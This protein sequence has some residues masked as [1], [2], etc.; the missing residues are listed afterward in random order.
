M[1]DATAGLGEVYEKVEAEITEK[2]RNPHGGFGSGKGGHYPLAAWNNQAAMWVLDVH[3]G[4][5]EAEQDL[6]YGITRRVRP[7]RGGSERNT[8]KILAGLP[9]LS[10]GADY[11]VVRALAKRLE[12][13]SFRG[14]LI[15]GLVDPYS[16]L[17]R[18][19]GQG[20]PQCPFCSSPGT[21]RVAHATGIVV[22]LRPGCADSNGNRTRGRIEPGRF[23]GEQS[24]VWSDGQTGVARA[25]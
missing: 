22:C 25:A 21:L 10:A 2:R 8:E 17:P 15:L 5:R 9:S 12:N 11:V 19:P 3:A 1:S 16:R 4:L 6:A 20:D 24:I 18:L 14:Q 7:P 13:W 23:S